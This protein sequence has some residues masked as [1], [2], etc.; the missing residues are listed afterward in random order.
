MSFGLLKRRFIGSPRRVDIE[1]TAYR[2]VKLDTTCTC[3][4]LHKKKTF[5]GFPWV[6]TSTAGRVYDL[7]LHLAN[8]AR[9]GNLLTQSTGVLVIC[10][11]HIYYYYFLERKKTGFEQLILLPGEGG[12]QTGFA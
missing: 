8:T 5:C 4:A 3:L 6:E 2:I 1:D 12:G 11:L 9:A 7:C 10:N